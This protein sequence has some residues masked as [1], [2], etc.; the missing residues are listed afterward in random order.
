MHD[1]WCVGV[2]WW[3]LAD[4]WQIRVK[5]QMSM[6][7]IHKN[8]PLGPVLGTEVRY[9]SDQDQGGS[10]GVPLAVCQ[11]ILATCQKLESDGR[12][13]LDGFPSIGKLPV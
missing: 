7:K 13:P 3:P 11:L 2:S 4:F 1:F 12:P 10:G 6:S 8:C 9:G 5:G